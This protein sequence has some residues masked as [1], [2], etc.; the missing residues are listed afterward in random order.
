MTARLQQ[1]RAA[2]GGSV[3][4]DRGTFP[5]PGHSPHDRSLS[6]RDTG[7][8]LLI[9]CFSGHSYREILDHLTTLGVDAGLSARA[10]LS[11]EDRVTLRRQHENDLARS[12][13]IE[14]AKRKRALELLGQASPLSAESVVY[15]RSR[16]IGRMAI[17]QA[18]LVGDL[19]HHPNCPRAPY[20]PDSSGRPALIAAV[21][22]PGGQM[23][24]AHVT[25]LA[26]DGHG[27]AFGKR[28]RLML[29]QQAGGV[30][31]L[32]KPGDVLGVAEGIETALSFATLFDVP[33]W[34]ARSADGLAMFLPPPSV[35]EVWIAADNDA[36]GLAAAEKLK[37]RLRVRSRLFVPDNGDWP[38]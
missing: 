14:A 3:R 13:E 2:V 5:A 36:A 30:I 20:Q 27:K 24:G 34:S 31:R 33:C 6:I 26:R 32:A 21:R 8:R 19:L 18:A 37:S 38:L 23:L 7:D 11:H 28:S 4:G 16:C 15:L 9:H 10:R 1:I 25:F 12:R 29:G 22:S 17:Q 35:R